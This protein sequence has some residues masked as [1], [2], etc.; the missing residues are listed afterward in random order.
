MKYY[1]VTDDPNELMHFGIKG[2][3]WGIRRTDAQLGHPRHTGSKRPRSAAYKKASAKLSSMMKN[4]IAK[5]ETKWK[6]YKS[7]ENVAKRAAKRYEKQTEKAIEKARKGKLKYGKLD[8]WQVQ[9]ITER[10]AMENNAR[11]LSETEKTGWK[12][13]REAVGEGFISGIGQGV[14]R[15]TSEWVARGSILKTDR[16]RMEQQDE[17][18]RAKEQRRI[19]NAEKQADRKV[20]RERVEQ[21]L[22]DRYE[23]KRDQKYQE[24]KARNAYLYGAKYDNDGKLLGDSYSAYYDQRFN[25]K[26]SLQSETARA[27]RLANKESERQKRLEADNRRKEYSASVKR[28][29][30]AQRDH[31]TRER[32]RAEKARQAELDRYRKGMASLSSEASK[33]DESRAWES[34]QKRLAENREKEAYRSNV[35]SLAEVSGKHAK[36]TSGWRA[37]DRMEN[38]ISNTRSSPSSWENST[39]EITRT[40]RRNRGGRN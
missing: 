9:R 10:L 25:K 24:E 7:P 22:K 27:E 8:D 26:K 19:R 39:Y 15:R 31:E 35:H 12:K 20:A 23:H 2:M 6:I 40:R 18:E 30:A 1:A 34:K 3:K 21:Q 16:K 38:G 5:A 29:E 11:R 17:F 28:L 4:G 37:I 14:G 36:A 33:R 32:E 13:L